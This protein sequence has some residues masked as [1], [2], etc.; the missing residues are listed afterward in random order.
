[1]ISKTDYLNILDGTQKSI[2]SILSSINHSKDFDLKTMESIDNGL[3]IRNTVRDNS[4]QDQ[5]KIY[6]K[7]NI[8]QLSKLDNNF[9]TEDLRK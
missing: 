4:Y 7:N 9:A 3:K 5:I 1:M 2:G 6:R 8:S